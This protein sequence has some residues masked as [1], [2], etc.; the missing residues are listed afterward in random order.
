MIVFDIELVEKI[1]NIVVENSGG[2]SG[3]R[4]YGLLDSAISS[5]NQTFMGQELYPTVYEKGARL[6]YNLISNHAFIDGNKRI[7][8]LTMLTFLKMNGV[9]LNYTDDDLIFLGISTAAGSTSYENLL[10]WINSHKA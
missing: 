3:V 1:H 8:L 7:G 9:E 2:S 10:N 6:G 5:I 4:D